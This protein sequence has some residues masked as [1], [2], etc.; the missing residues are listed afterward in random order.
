MSC[1]RVFSFLFVFFFILRFHYLCF[2]KIDCVL[3]HYISLSHRYL[4]HEATEWLGRRGTKWSKELFTNIQPVKVPILE[5][6]F[7]L[8]DGKFSSH[9]FGQV[10]TEEHVYQRSDYWLDYLWCQLA[11]GWDEARPGCYLIPLVIVHHN[12]R[13]LRAN[14]DSLREEGFAIRHL[15]SDHPKFG[16][17]LELSSKWAKLVGKQDM[18]MIEKR[19]NENEEEDDDD[20]GLQPFNLEA[21]SEL[22]INQNNHYESIKT[23]MANTN[24]S[25]FR[26]LLE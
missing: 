20:D 16:K 17:L 18:Q 6:S 22:F 25:R 5:Q 10:L 7:A 26:S 14:S 23:S 3:I 21:C 8:F 12:T 19:C 9:F 11:A 1:A 15:F 4:Y 2:V 24:A 13:Q